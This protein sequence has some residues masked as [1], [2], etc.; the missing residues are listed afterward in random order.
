MPSSPRYVSIPENLSSDFDANRD[1]MSACLLLSMLTPNFP[2]A[3]MAS[4]VFTLFSIQISTSG[5]RRESDA[6][7]ATVMP[8]GRPSCS[9][10]T[11]V[12]PLAK[13]DIASLNA[14]SSMGIAGRSLT[15]S[16]GVRTTLTEETSMFRSR[17]TLS[18]FLITSAAYAVEPSIHRTFN[19][20]PG[21]TLTIDADVGDIRVD[22]GGNGVTVDVT[23]RTN[24]SKRHLEV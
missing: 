5:G 6:N 15:F 23:Q 22:P 13:C 24:V 20:A 12:T 11:T 10:V 21:G 19:V 17:I 16:M 1:E 8:Y 9:V 2:A 3:T 18:I 4:C 14:A 7:E